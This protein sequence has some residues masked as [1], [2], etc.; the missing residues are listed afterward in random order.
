MSHQ[1][2]DTVRARI[3]AILPETIELRHRLHS[4][5]ELKFEEFRTMELIRDFLS[6]GK[7]ELLAPIIGTDTIGL[8]R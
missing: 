2:S 6:G 7:I 8:L 3:R 5:P 1:L 4:N